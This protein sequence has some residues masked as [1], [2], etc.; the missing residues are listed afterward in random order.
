MDSLVTALD[1][2]FVAGQVF[3]S[4]GLACGAYLCIQFSSLLSIPTKERRAIRP[5][6]TLNW[7]FHG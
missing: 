7:R 4:V 3:A 2:I 5:V 1:V 6:E